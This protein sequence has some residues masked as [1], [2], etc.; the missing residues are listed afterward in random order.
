MARWT[1]VCT[2]FSM[3]CRL[4]PIP[5]ANG[6]RARRRKYWGR[7]AHERQPRTVGAAART[8]ALHRLQSGARIASIAL[9]TIWGC[10]SITRFMLRVLCL[11]SSRQVERGETPH[12]F[13]DDA[14]QQGFLLL[15]SVIGEIAHD[16][17][18]RC[19]LQSA[20]DADRMQEPSLPSV[21]SGEQPSL[22]RRS[23]IA[24]AILIACSILPWRSRD[25]WLTPSMVRVAAVG[26]EGLVLDIPRGFAVDGVGKIGAELFQVDLV[27]AA[28]NSLVGR[29]QAL[30]GTML[31]LRILQKEMR[32]IHDFGETG[33]VVG[34]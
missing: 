11:I 20:R 10:R 7:E 6:T 29:E 5:D 32:C 28:T 31:D 1:I 22:G 16:K 4:Y 18:E 8:L 14:F 13:L 19:F 27:D 15:Q 2:A 21:V 26:G 33:L 12:Y 34:P 24:A 9:S 3:S 17:T 25:G 30:I 23:T